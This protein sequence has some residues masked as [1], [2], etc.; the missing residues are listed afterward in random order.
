M[1]CIYIY[2]LSIHAHVNRKRILI[3]TRFTTKRKNESFAFNVLNMTHD[4]VCEG[5]KVLRVLSSATQG[6]KSCCVY[7][8]PQCKLTSHQV[9][10]MWCQGDAL[11]Y[12]EHYKLPSMLWVGTCQFTTEAG[13]ILW[14]CP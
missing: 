2:S 1:T 6:L 5:I 12:T 11:S 10:F 4:V 9:Q 13:K 3:I 14:P 8:A 7:M